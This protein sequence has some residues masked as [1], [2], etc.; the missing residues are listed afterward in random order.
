MASVESD[1]LDLIKSMAATKRQTF[2]KVRIPNA[3]PYFFTSLKISITLALIGAIVGEFVGGEG[4]LGYQIILANAR[5]DAPRLFAIIFVLTVIGAVLFY[6][7]SGLERFILPWKPAAEEA[8]AT[9]TGTKAT[10]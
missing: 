7:V 1:M 2:G 4:G 8:G 9:V 3:L 5:M 10:F 6:I